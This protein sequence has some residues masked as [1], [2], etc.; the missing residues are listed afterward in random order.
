MFGNSGSGKS[1]LARQLCDLHSLSYLDLDDI[2]WQATSP[3]LRQPFAESER[4]IIG[5]IHSSPA[6]VIEG[7]YTDLLE[8]A[9][10]F[11]TE[12]IYL[13][14]PVET[15]IAN[16]RKRPWEPHKYDSKQAQDANL[17]MLVDWIAQYEQR[18]DTFSAD[19][20][21][22]LFEGYPGEKT[23]YTGNDRNE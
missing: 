12:I 17:G 4:Q 11:A 14:L 5:F 8:I 9:A 21:R 10:P 23:V 22:C 16:A 18:Q 6:W 19:A 13:N 7:C 1:T 3:P 20:H 15:C 2:A